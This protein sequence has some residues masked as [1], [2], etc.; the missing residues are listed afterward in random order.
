MAPNEPEAASPSPANNNPPA[1]THPP[2]ANP[3][4]GTTARKAAHWL[5]IIGVLLLLATLGFTAKDSISQDSNARCSTVLSSVPA[6][7]S[8]KDNAGQLRII[9]TWPAQ[10][11]LGSRLCVAIA[12]VAA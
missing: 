3:I 4:V 2:R 9:G 1:A 11:Q 10:L 7:T 8:D 5:G 12:G 6:D